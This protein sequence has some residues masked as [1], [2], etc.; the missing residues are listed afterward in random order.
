MS[1]RSLP[2]S[3]AEGGAAIG[4]EPPASEASVISRGMSSGSKSDEWIDGS[5]YSY[6]GVGEGKSSGMMTTLGTGLA[7]APPHIPQGSDSR[8]AL[9]MRSMERD[10]G[11]ASL[12]GNSS[13]W[14]GYEE[15]ASRP[16]V[17]AEAAG[18]KGGE[19]EG[20]LCSVAGFSSA[21]GKKRARRD[22]GYDR[23]ASASGGKGDKEVQE[24]RI[25][26]GIGEVAVGPGGCHVERPVGGK[27]SIE[28][29][30]DVACRGLSALS[31]EGKLDVPHARFVL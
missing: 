3:V 5:T 26:A 14:G 2:V 7:S 29:A 27:D 17:Q 25:H 4:R 22:Q 28:V 12:D 20:L 23:L 15:R 24:G 19:G 9:P 11:G 16:S 10:Q 30:F 21:V 1:Q 13:I 18:A 6:D 8:S 31:L